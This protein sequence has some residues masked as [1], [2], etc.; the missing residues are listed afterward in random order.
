VSTSV[1]ADVGGVGPVANC[2]GFG[3]AARGYLCLYNTVHNNVDPGYG[4]SS[5][6]SELQ[7][8]PWIG[9]FL[10]WQVSGLDAYVGGEWAV[11]AP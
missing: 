9:V 4:Y 7:Q 3:Q 6:S 11:T 1:F 2:P 8:T 5:D 10:Y